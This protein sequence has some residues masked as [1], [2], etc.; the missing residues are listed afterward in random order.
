[1]VSFMWLIVCISIH[2]FSICRWHDLYSHYPH[3]FF[4]F[5][6]NWRIITLQ[7]C[8]GFCHTTAWIIHKYAYMPS[9]EPLPHPHIPPLCR[10]TAPRAMQPLPTSCLSHVW[11]W[12]GFVAA[13]AIHPLLSFPSCV[14]KSVFYVCISIP[15]L[16]IGSSAPFF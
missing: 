8:V 5:I 3:C 7:C 14:L 13:V 15:A 2:A 4:K 16:Q 10:H 9:L 11:W 1:M 6:F 12:T